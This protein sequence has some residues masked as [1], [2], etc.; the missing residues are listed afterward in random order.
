MILFKDSGYNV[1]HNTVSNF[2]NEY[3]AFHFW[4]L[5]IQCTTT[6]TNG[7]FL[8]LMSPVY[9]FISLA[10]LGKM[11]LQSLSLTLFFSL[12]FL[13]RHWFDLFIC[14]FIWTTPTELKLSTY[15]YLQENFILQVL[16]QVRSWN[17]FQ[18]NHGFDK[19]ITI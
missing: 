14:S 19:L 12:Y 10:C 1:V 4:V 7:I 5:V 6:L 2:F 18:F 13:F 3:K 11:F 15:I 17:A 9:I 16:L 8:L